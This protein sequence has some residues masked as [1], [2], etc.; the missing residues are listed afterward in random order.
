MA[1][2]PPKGNPAQ[3]AAVSFEEVK[4]GMEKSMGRWKDPLMAAVML[5]YYNLN[6][7]KD[8]GLLE[9]DE[10]KAK[11]VTWLLRVFR[12]IEKTDGGRYRCSVIGRQFVAWLIEKKHLT[13]MDGAEFVIKY[14]PR[15]GRRIM[16]DTVFIPNAQPNVE[17]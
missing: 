2:D 14:G 8:V 16:Y 5:P 9:N 12:I 15:F 4:N 17:A 1:K 7:I 6:D 13:P 3:P 11:D 10:D